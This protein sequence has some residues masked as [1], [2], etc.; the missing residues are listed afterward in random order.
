MVLIEYY[1]SKGACD[2]HRKERENRRG[3]MIEGMG[4]EVHKI[5]RKE[6]G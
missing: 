4:T 5:C 6:G 2:H 1:G 3:T